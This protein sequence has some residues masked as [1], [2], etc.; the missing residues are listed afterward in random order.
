MTEKLQDA[1]DLLGLTKA[2]VSST[3]DFV[4]FI[5][6]G[7]PIKAVAAVAKALALTPAATVKSL[8]VAERTYARRVEKRQRFSVDESE[9]IVRL[10]RVLAMATDVMGDRDRARHWV[11]EP[12][13]ALGNVSPLTLL[14]TDIGADAVFDELGRIEYGVF[15]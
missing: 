8:G 10:A 12:S 1:A 3:L 15:A 2:K 14:D 7:L 6:K 13:R 11:V 5:R 4:P 9:R